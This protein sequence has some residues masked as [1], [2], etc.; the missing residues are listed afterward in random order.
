MSWGGV[1]KF[2]S[3]LCFLIFLFSLFLRGFFNFSLRN[4]TFDI[5]IW[6]KDFLVNCVKNTI[7]FSTCLSTLSI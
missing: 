4:A 7:R 1:L 5:N 2:M 6:Q 3:C